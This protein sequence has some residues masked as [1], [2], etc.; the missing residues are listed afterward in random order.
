MKLVR[1]TEQKLLQLGEPL[2]A[3]GQQAQLLLDQATTPRDAQRQRTTEAFNA[4]LSSPAHIRTQS[5]RLTHGQK[6]RH[7]KLV[8]E[9][10]LANL[11]RKDLLPRL[12][13]GYSIC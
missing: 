7:C 9:Q 2:T 3:L 10:H 11:R 13:P 5:T 12:R 6:L 4:A 1:H 8:N